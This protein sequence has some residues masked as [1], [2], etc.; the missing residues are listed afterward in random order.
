MLKVLSGQTQV[1]G[2]IAAPAFGPAIFCVRG[3]TLS[4]QCNLTVNT[5]SAGVFAAASVSA[6]HVTITA[7]GY[8]TGLVGQLTS[9][10]SLPTGLSLATNYFIIVV[11]ANT[12]S[13][14]SSLANAQAG[15]AIAITGGSGNSTFTAT[16]LATGTV[17]L[18]KSNDGLGWDVDGSA[19]SFTATGT[20][21]L[22]KTI[23]TTQFMRVAYSLASGSISSSTV[24]FVQGYP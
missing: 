12:V 8:P 10:G 23:T 13:F 7:H 24:V 21:V 18:Q 3:A 17:Q 1:T 5:P 19:V 11:D 6:N 4:A 16:A 15:T 14:A 22:E 9:A 2:N 20:K